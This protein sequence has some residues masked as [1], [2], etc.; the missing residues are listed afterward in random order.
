MSARLYDWIIE[1]KELLKKILPVSLLRKLKSLVIRMRIRLYA[2]KPLNKSICV[3]KPFGVN[4]IG[5]IQIESGLGQSMRLVA[6]ELDLSKID[7]GIFQ[8]DI[9]SGVRRNDHSWDQKLSSETPYR[10]NLFHINPRELGTAFLG[11][12]PMYWE[13]HYNIAFWLWEL[14]EFPK[15]NLFALKFADEIWTP[16]EF[17]SNCIRRI[18][19]KPVYTLPYLVTAETDERYDRKHFGLPEDK[20]LYLAMFDFHSV[21]IRKNPQGA[22]KAF[23]QA[24]EKNDPDVGLVIKVNNPS[25]EC[26][27]ELKQLLDGYENVYFITRTL[28][29]AEV[30]SLIRCADVFVS[31]HRAEGFGL[32]LAEAMLVQTACIATNWSANTE[33]MNPDVACMVSYKK[34]PIQKGECLYPAGALWAEPDIDEA[35]AFMKRLRDDPVFYQEKV[36]RAYQHVSEVLGK[37][38]IVSLLEKRIEEINRTLCC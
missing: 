6:N 1:H 33:F 3:R 20:F 14:E 9:T 24:F 25:D 37:E 7:F 28:D 30:N 38:K 18:T 16:S 13:N 31:L 27:A 12:G 8:F 26:M 34:I 36:E 21:M 22:I 2:P 10:I 19:D 32:V 17:N 35:A 5:D 29:K 11:L 23:Q 4:L 15:E